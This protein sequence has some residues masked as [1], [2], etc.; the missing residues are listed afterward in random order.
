MVTPSDIETIKWLLIAIF[1]FIVIIALS[2]S[3]IAVVSWFSYGLVK[4]SQKGAVFKKRAEQ[5][6]SNSNNKELI[7]LAN[8]RITDSP[9]DY[10]AY[11]YLAKVQ[12]HQGDLVEAKRN[13]KKV[14]ELDP[15]M[16]YSASQWIEEINEKLESGPQLI[17]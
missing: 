8:E 11:W 6:L 2:F 5:L 13:F 15:T 1:V 14:I 17:K 10:L 7:E 12:F 16:D 4:E 3:I 9:Q